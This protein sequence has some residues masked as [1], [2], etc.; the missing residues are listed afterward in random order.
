MSVYPVILSFE[1]HCSLEQTKRMAYYVKTIFKEK[2]FLIPKDYDKFE[3]YPSPNQLKC[4]IIIKSK[5]T[6]EKAVNENS[7]LGFVSESDEDQDEDVGS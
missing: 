4:K 6:V 3:Y 2:L 7:L 5:G 1:N